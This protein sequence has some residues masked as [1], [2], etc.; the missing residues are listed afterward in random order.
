MTSFESLAKRS[1]DDHDESE[2]LLLLETIQNLLE[3][4]GILSFHHLVCTIG[5]FPWIKGVLQS[6]LSRPSF[7]TLAMKH[8]IV[9]LLH[10]ALDITIQNYTKAPS[11]IIF[12][13]AQLAKAL[14]Q[15]FTDTVGTGEKSNKTSGKD[16]IFASCVS[17]VLWL[18]R[19]LDC[20]Q[21]KERSDNLAFAISHSGIPSEQ[22]VTLL[23]VVKGERSTLYKAV[24]ALCYFPMSVSEG[25]HKVVVQ[26]CTTSLQCILDNHHHIDKSI[27]VNVIHR[28]TVLIRYFKCHLRD[29]VRLLEMILGARQKA[30]QFSESSDAWF[31]CLS[32][33]VEQ[34]K[35]QNGEGKSFL[36]QIE[37]LKKIATHVNDNRLIG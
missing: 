16:V 22:G 30:M 25:H 24:G 8:K 19:E 14:I 10:C 17:E 5:L 1:D 12:E 34:D 23:N 11:R 15:L 4:G 2:G 28:I 6:R 3:N 21:L 33:L 37:L 20:L 18:L 7:A 31:S 29:D 9:K 36:R 26:L 27:S 32:N 13:P 35:D